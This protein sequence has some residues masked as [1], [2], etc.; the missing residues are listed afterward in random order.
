MY[1]HFS[2][3]VSEMQKEREL[4]SFMPLKMV[5]QVSDGVILTGLSSFIL[6]R[7][8][9]PLTTRYVGM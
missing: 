4:T 7:E 1:F 2:F 8:S 5:T 9:P 3:F 6:A